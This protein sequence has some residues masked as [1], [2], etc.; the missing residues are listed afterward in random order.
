MLLLIQQQ[1]TN[2]SVYFV[3]LVF[4]FYIIFALDQ[5]QN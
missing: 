2:V 1:K 5:S 4:K 3:L